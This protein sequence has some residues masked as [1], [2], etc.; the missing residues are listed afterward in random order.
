MT[1]RKRLLV[2]PLIGIALLVGG[3]GGGSDVAP[4]TGTI[5]LDGQPL[6]SAEVIF[7]PQDGRPSTGL[8]DG[9]GRYELVF[10]RDSKGAL[11]GSH[12]VRI[13]VPTVDDDGNPLPDAR[14]L[15]VKYNVESTLTAQVTAGSNLIDF[16]LTLGD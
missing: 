8:T 16:P 1:M 3:C 15:P 9:Q 2:L 13:T 7:Q 11:I 5:T 10:S 14:P 4:V 6:A 12:T